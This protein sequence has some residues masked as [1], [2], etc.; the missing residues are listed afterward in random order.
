[1]T[2]IKMTYYLDEQKKLRELILYICLKSEGDEKFGLTKLNKLLFFSDFAFYYDH[3]KSIT[4][5]EYQKLQQGPAP[6]LMKPLLDDMI[7]NGEIEVLKRKFFGHEQRKPY[8]KREPSLS[9]FSGEEIA[10]VDAVIDRLKPYSGSDVSEISH[11]FPGWQ[12]AQEG[13][14]IPYAAVYIDNSPLSQE[15]KDFAKSLDLSGVE[16]L[17]AANA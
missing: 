12:L 10:L 14:A 7:S 16:E 15:D 9:E 17:L 6:K 8:A 2:P 11:Q 4:N 3:R 5:A 1:M 13:Q